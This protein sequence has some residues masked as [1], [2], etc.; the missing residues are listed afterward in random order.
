MFFL[1]VGFLAG[2][3]SFAQQKDS[4]VVSSTD[5]LRYDTTQVENPKLIIANGFHNGDTL[6]VSKEKK[7]KGWSRPKKALIWAMVLPGAGQV[8][9]KKYWKL[10]I[11][12]A[13]IGAV[14]YFWVTNQLGFAEFRDA[15]DRNYEL[16]AADPTYD[17]FENNL[18]YGSSYVYTNLDQ[19]ATERN[20]YRRYRDMSIAGAIALYAISMMD[21]YVDAH[22]STFDLKDDLSLTISPSFYNYNATFVPGLS[23]SLNFKN[24]RIPNNKLIKSDF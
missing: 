1:F 17:V 4:L 18:K 20:T 16:Q 23:L 10:P 14:T 13:G 3:N 24:N 5:S 9:N 8:Y 2:N 15:Y 21:A 22:L 12:Y 6:L 7:N 19:L 11:L